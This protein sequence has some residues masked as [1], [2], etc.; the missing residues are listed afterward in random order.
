MVPAY[1]AAS[2][3]KQ[4]NSGFLMWKKAHCEVQV[5]NTSFFY[6]GRAVISVSFT[7][8]GAIVETREYLITL[9]PAEIRVYTFDATV[10]SNGSQVTLL[11]APF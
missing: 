4:W 8:D 6:T 1:L 7:L 5:M 9:A 11:P 2:V 3:T 10:N